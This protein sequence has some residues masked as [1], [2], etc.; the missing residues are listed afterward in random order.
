MKLTL[1]AAAIPSVNITASATQICPGQKVT[2]IATPTNGG[3]AP[4]YQWKINAVNTIAANDTLVMNSLNNGDVINCTLT[5]SS[6]CVITQTA[7][8]NNITI[9]VDPKFA[10]AAFLPADTFICIDQPKEIRSTG[11]YN[12][13]LWNTNAVTASIVADQPG[14]YWL[15][16]TDINDC[17][18]RDTI[19]LSPKD[20]P[21]GFYIPSAF[22]PNGDGKNDLFMPLLF[23]NVKQYKFSV[24][25]RWGQIIFRTTELNKGWDGTIKGIKQNGGVYVWICT[26]QFAGEEVKTA[27]GT[28]M[29]IR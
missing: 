8:S 23:G 9:T 24:Y 12:S 13:Y 26:Y 1:P 25:N 3:A 10:P 29:A 22:T 5:N 2:F 14:M 7:V 4:S 21:L 16:V 17:K 28:V 20:C 19:V 15:Q 11:N 27:K 18:G 6:L